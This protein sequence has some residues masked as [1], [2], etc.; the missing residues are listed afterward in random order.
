MVVET[1]KFTYDPHGMIDNSPFIPSSQRKK[2][3]E[4]YWREGTTLNA[5]AVTEDPLVKDATSCSLSNFPPV[6]QDDQVGIHA[7]RPW[8]L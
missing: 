6:W 5:D 3:A 4:R 2:V 7:V 1:T 8:N